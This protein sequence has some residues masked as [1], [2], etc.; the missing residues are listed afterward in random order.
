VTLSWDAVYP[1][2]CLSC[3]EML[4]ELTGAAVRCFCGQRAAE[5]TEALTQIRAA[6]TTPTRAAVRNAR[7][8]E[9]FVEWSIGPAP[10]DDKACSA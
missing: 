3:V 9:V 7:R 10:M 2:T 5:A 6:A 4:A 8:G 1:V